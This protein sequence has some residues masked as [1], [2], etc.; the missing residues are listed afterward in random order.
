MKTRTLIVTGLAALAI[1]MASCKNTGKTAK[2][3]A[4]QATIDSLKMEIVKKQV[5]DSMNAIAMPLASPVASPVPET[6]I[7]VVR[8]Q[9]KHKTVKRK[10]KASSASGYSSNSYAGNTSNNNNNNNSYAAN[11][12]YN[13]APAY[14]APAPVQQETK[15]GWSSKAKAGVIGTGAGA[16][17]GAL[18]D[19]KKGRGALI[20]GLLGAASGIGVGAIMDNREKRNNQ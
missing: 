19:K 5:I 11:E 12:P 9:P 17:A 15:K 8:E 3:E 13:P 2:T 14:E 10:K 6:R 18:I 20:G 7:V 1:G 16:I 4:Q